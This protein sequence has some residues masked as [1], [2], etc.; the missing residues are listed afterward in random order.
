MMFLVFR[1]QRG[2]VPSQ[3]FDFLRHFFFRHGVWIGRL[4]LLV[5]GR[6]FWRRL[7]RHLILLF[8]RGQMGQCGVL[9]T[10]P[11]FREE[12]LC[13]LVV[14]CFRRRCHSSRGEFVPRGG[15]S[16]D[17]GPRTRERDDAE[18]VRDRLERDTII[19]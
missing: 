7:I 5:V 1:R 18:A 15:A 17:E 2:H 19:G 3:L 14:G 16:G 6:V 12:G 13:R 4:L 10:I 9:F 8:G 11:E